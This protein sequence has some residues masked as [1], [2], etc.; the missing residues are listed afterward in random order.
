MNIPDLPPPAQRLVIDQAALAANWRALA[1][2]AGSPG[3]AVG[4]AVKADAYGLGVDLVVPALRAAGARDFF[5]AHWAE[6]RAVM[7]HAP[8]ASIAVLH[9][10]GNGPEAHFARATGVRPVLN[11]L[12]QV[13]HWLEAGGGPCHLMVDTGMNRLGLAPHE[14]G[15]PSLGLLAIEVLHSHL[16]SADEASAQNE[17]QL[18]LFCQCAP[19]VGA[20][21]LALANSAGI[22]LGRAYHFDL[23]RPGLALYGGIAHRSLADCIRP[24]FR[25]EAAVLQV[26]DLGAGD[27]VGYNA[28]FRAPRAMRAATV[29]LGYAD[30]LLRA[31][32]GQAFLRHQGVIL[33]V[34]GRIS[35]DLVVVD[36]TAA[37]GLGEGDLVEVPWSLPQV[38]QASGLSHY[39]ALT[40]LGRRLARVACT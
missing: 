36:C 26:R 4:A 33:P 3:V 16:A 9:G 25:L 24:A 8:A 23:V 19:Q 20:P 39:E 11:S 30:G 18:R 5:V 6:A 17:A 12:L 31:F 28:T 15:D 37:P 10:V 35:M 22:A 14:L 40:V 29:C 38:A 1:D 32:E 27:P 13:R 2:L 7:A 34:V 21:R